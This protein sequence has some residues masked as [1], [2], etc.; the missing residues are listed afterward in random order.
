MPYCYTQKIVLSCHTLGD[1]WQGIATI[2]PVLIN[3]AQPASS[4]SRVVMVL[5]KGSEV[6]TLDSEEGADASITI[7]DA[8]T[9][10]ASIPEVQD[11]VQSA[12][13]WH[14]SMRFY[15]DGD[16]SPQTLYSG[17]LKVEK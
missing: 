13:R 1:K 10:E 17:K 9:W 3:E 14:W 5:K 4:L 8:V 16:T 12:G 7:G 15:G 11:F 2:G 6:F